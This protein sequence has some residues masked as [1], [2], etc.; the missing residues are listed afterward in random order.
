MERIKIKDKEP[1][2][3]DVM[4]M[5]EKTIH[6]FGFDPKLIAL[7]KLRVSQINGCG[8][9]MDMHSF[10]GRKAGETDQRLFTVGAWWETDFFTE[11][12]QAA[13]KLAEQVTRISEKGVSDKVYED[14]I[15][16]FGEQGFAQ[17]I[18]IINTINS[19][20]RIAISTYMKPLKVR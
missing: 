3:Y 12:E 10:E 15:H 9:C 8:Y 5:A 7:I 16:H 4:V 11:Q 1:R 18:L 17:L 6:A 20:N 14:V 13:L 2:V 19:W